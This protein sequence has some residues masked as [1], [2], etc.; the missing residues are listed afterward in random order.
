MARNS[1]TSNREM[2]HDHHNVKCSLGALCRISLYLVELQ[3]HILLS[4]LSVA[5]KKIPDE[6][7]GF[8]SLPLLSLPVRWVNSG[9]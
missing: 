2:Y 1:R 4:F 3:P 8:R 5:E 6:D 9:C 7:K